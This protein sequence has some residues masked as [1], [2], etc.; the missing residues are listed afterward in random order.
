[1]PPRCAH[2]TGVAVR[3]RRPRSCCLPSHQVKCY[4][5]K[6]RSATRDVI[7]RLQF[8][9][10]A[11]Q[12]YS[13]VFR[14]EDLDGASK[15]EVPAAW[16]GPGFRWGGAWGGSTGAW[17]RGS[18]ADGGLQAPLLCFILY[19]LVP[20]SHGCLCCWV[21][22]GALGAAAWSAVAVRLTLRVSFRWPVSC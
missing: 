10:G 15:G 6:Y 11:V 13:L 1:M 12:G 20:A 14:K 5:K 16:G 21:G 7:F 8:H 4:H 19:S 3:S 18:G 22:H 17:R 2:L 9:T